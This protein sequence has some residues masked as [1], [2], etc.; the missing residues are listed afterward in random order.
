LNGRGRTGGAIAFLGVVALALVIG[1]GAFY[2]GAAHGFSA[3]AIEDTIKSW[4]MWGVAASLCLMIVHSF[5]PFPAEFVAF[6]NGMIYGPLWGTVITWCG[7]MLGALTAFGL[8]RAL[9][10]P[11]VAIMVARHSLDALDEWTARR[12]GYV[13][14]IARLI[15][16]IAFNLINYAAGLTRLPWWTFTWTTGLGILPLTIVMV[17]MGAHVELLSWPVWLLIGLLSVAL[18]FALRHRLRL[19]PRGLSRRGGDRTRRDDR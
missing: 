9:G 14:L 17:V 15:P 13:V 7:A 16:V 3:T 5:V 8:A 2:F 12:G 10:R 11:F 1:T 4:G 6:A 19:P 18:W